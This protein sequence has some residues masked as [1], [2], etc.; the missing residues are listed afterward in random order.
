MP[1][2]TV[3]IRVPEPLYRRLQRLAELTQRPLESLVVQALSSSIPLLPDDLPPA[4]R[5]ALLALE[6]LSDSEL[7]RVADARFSPER[8]ERLAALRE[9]R[10]TNTL[11]EGEQAA[12]DH[13]LQEADLLT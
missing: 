10:R 1:A 6:D 8:Y 12:L 2:D 3:A 7:Q 4:M 9:K 5:D 13:L 11:A